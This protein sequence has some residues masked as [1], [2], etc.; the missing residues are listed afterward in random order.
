MKINKEMP[1]IYLDKY[2][3]NVNQYL[4]Y[5][6]I[7]QIINST[8]ALSKNKETDSKGNKRFTNSW[9]ERQVNIDMLILYYATDISKEDLDE[10]EHSIFLYSGLID[11]VMGCIKNIDLIYEALDY[12]ESWKKAFADNIDILSTV[13]NQF[14]TVAQKREKIYE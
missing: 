14:Q 13:I 10:I 1:T 2:D 3:I 4:T 6:Q 9:A 11:N 12:T 5:D 7:Q 8:I